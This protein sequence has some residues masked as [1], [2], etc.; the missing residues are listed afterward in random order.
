[1]R[2]ETGEFPR[3]ALD[4]GPPRLSIG[5]IGWLRRNLFSTWLNSL[6]TVV[7]LWLIYELVTGLLSWG[8]VNAAF[9]TT[10]ESCRGSTGACWAMVIDN[11]YL[12]SVGT[13]PFEEKWRPFTAFAVVGV[14]AVASLFPR[15]RA[16]RWIRGLWLISPVYMLV[17]IRG[18]SAFHLN[19]VDTAQ[20]GGLMLTL[21][22][23]T[24]G[25]LASFPIGILLALGRRSKKMPVVK[26]ICV[27]YIEV[28]RG[29]PL[30]TVLFMSSVI[31]PL[32]FPPGWDMDKVL[33]AQLG[34][35]LFS[36]AYLAEVVRGGLQAIPRGQ[37]EAASAIG[38][39]YW[40]MMSFIILPQALRIMI[41][42][43]V[44][45]AIGLFKDT[46]LVTIIGLIDFLTIAT[47]VTA[48]PDWIGTITEA[49]VFIAAVY[50]IFCFG[51]SRYSQRLETRFKAGY[52]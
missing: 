37:E 7:A 9:G 5:V 49:Y 27:V 17:M 52:Q 43:L 40:Q 45:G 12:F 11:W 8:L 6:F 29:V 33:R 48:N 23:S 19:V 2:S 20:W 26:S 44:S 28:I 46:S 31:I 16:S 1:M 47:M 21:I 10:R 34:I 4:I 51:M 24:V 15:L 25:I 14:L 18:G 39:N 38:L 41:P 30:I 3:E 36:A 50:W 42:A 32:F 22:L 13:Y 35:I